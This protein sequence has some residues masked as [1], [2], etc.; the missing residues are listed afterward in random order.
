MREGVYAKYPVVDVKA[1]LIDGSYHEVDSSEIA[2][3][4][5]AKGCFKNAFI[6]CKPILLEPCMSLEII[7][8]EEHTSSIVGYICSKRGRIINMDTKGSQKII[9]AEAPLS[10][11][12]GCTTN[13]RSLSS[14]R[15]SCSMHF[16]KYTEVPAEITKKIIEEKTAKDS[17]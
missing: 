16:E 12:F 6:K 1:E 17:K 15:A 10:E 13:L 14:G 8:P 9:Q 5:A 4:L 11:M 3:K 7:T 2:F